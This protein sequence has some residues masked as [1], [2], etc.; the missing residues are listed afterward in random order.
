MW[1]RD[2]FNQFKAK[3][4][5]LRKDIKALYLAY[6]RPDVP[7]YAKLFAIFVVSY[8]LSP[9][10]LIPDFVPIL[11]YLD[12]LVL[13]PLG[14]TLAI[15]MIPSNVMQEC[16]LQAEDAFINGKPK[17]WVSGIVIVLIWVVVIG[18]IIFYTIF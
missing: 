15:K 12:D 9:V 17:S 4:R 6:K 1:L 7:W 16:R 11:G 8:A 18:L 5:S 3:A 14:I 10:D 2:S 13:I